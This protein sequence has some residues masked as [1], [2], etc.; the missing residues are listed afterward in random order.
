MKQVIIT[1]AI[2][3]GL[4]TVS[5]A[6]DISKQLQEVS[7][8]IHADK[9]QGSGVIVTREVDGEKVNFVWTAAHVVAGQRHVR[10]VIDPATGTSRQVVEFKDVG[11][12]KELVENGRKVGELKMD[13]KVIRYSDIENG[14]DLALLE[15]RK[16]DFVQANAKFYLLDDI[17]TIGTHL[18][19]VGSLLGQI[20]ANSMTSGIVSQIGRL[21]DE[22][23]FDQTTVTAFP[24]SSGGGVFLAEGEHKGE[25][26]GM[27]V[28]GAGEQFN[29]IVPVRRLK[30]WAKEA[31]I[32]WAIN[33]SVTTP[34]SKERSKMSIED[35]GVSFKS[36][37]DKSAS[38][39]QPPVAPETPPES[40]KNLLIVPTTKAILEK[41]FGATKCQCIK[42][43]KNC[44]CFHEASCGDPGCVRT[45]NP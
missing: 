14:Q 1:L 16:K 20:G 15:V 10:S 5:L 25:Y 27:L 33:E 9:S 32:E 36:G 8:T 41:L 23:I 18:F 26:M 39:S 4:A 21:I 28:R 42:C 2:I 45:P 34:S 6:D 37:G 35:I 7:V 40:K 29:L 19:H 30:D 43:D 11:I 24:G 17:P 13:A 44:K 38:P 12:V 31:K 22:K 3:L